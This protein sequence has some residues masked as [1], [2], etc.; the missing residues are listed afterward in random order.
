MISYCRLG[1][2][3]K[4]L[5]NVIVH[6]MVYSRRGVVS[7]WYTWVLYQIRDHSPSTANPIHVVHDH[8]HTLT[9]FCDH[10]ASLLPGHTCV[11]QCSHWSF[12]SWYNYATFLY[13][14]TCFKSCDLIG[15]RTFELVIYS[16]VASP[17]HSTSKPVLQVAWL[18][19][20][21]IKCSISFPTMGNKLIYQ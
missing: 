4:Y 18:V 9:G 8:R 20:S 1:F 2:N 19:K 14:A 7:G 16:I 12:N 6:Y 15:Q 5:L 3:C 17:V 13:L 11:V 21:S 10:T